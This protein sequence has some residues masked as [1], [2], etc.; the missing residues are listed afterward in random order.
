MGLF[1][2]EVRE[3][4]HIRSRIDRHTINKSR[5]L[6]THPCYA[7]CETAKLTL[8]LVPVC[9]GGSGAD[10][11]NFPSDV[12]ESPKL[13]MVLYVL[14]TLS[15]ALTSATLPFAL[16]D[17]HVGPIARWIP[18]LYAASALVA[19][20]GV[21][22]AY[23]STAKE[24][25]ASTVI[26]DIVGVRLARALIE[27]RLL[28][29]PSNRLFEP[30]KSPKEAYYNRTRFHRPDRRMCR[31]KWTDWVRSRSVRSDD[32]VEFRRDWLKWKRV[33]VSGSLT[34]LATL[35]RH[36]RIQVYHS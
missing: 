27:V 28:R 25:P 19:Y 21:G 23:A 6:R 11:S 32:A 36:L 18:S 12:N 10:P 29:G 7:I 1:R 31:I 3:T 20:S 24:A 35:V 13:T 15:P 4:H 9:T 26:R 8:G 34:K 33:E 22:V 2:C 5:A 17:P 14:N 16:G 30:P